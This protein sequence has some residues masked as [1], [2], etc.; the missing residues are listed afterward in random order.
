MQN[1][2]REIQNGMS[3]KNI[4]MSEIFYGTSKMRCGMHSI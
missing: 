1:G 2:I 3:K 4:S